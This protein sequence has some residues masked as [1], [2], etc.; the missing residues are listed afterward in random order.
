MTLARG[1]GVFPGVGFVGGA[2]TYR[3]RLNVDAVGSRGVE[4]DGAVERGAFD[5]RLSLSALSARVRASGPAA[6]LDGRR[7]AQVASLSGS[8]ALGWRLAVGA[9]L[10]ATL[11]HTGAQFE[12]DG[13]TR[14]LAPATVLDLSARLPLFGRLSGWVRLENALAERVEVA[15]DDD[16]V[17]E[18]ARPR[19]LMVGVTIRTP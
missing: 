18:R 5:A 10:V 14:A 3:Q 4:L 1:P 15:V 7:P 2:G 19:A 12:D 16:G 13:N 9:R 17:L 6:A 11:D 8:L